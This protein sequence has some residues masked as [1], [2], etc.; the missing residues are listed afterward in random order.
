MRFSSLTITTLCVML[1]ASPIL[2]KEKKHEKHMDEKAM[3]EMWQNDSD[4]RMDGAR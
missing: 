3:M 1:M 2:A 4:Q